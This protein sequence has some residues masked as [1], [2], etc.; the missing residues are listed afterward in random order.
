MFERLKK[1]FSNLFDSDKRQIKSLKT[2][3]VGENE[4]KALEIYTGL[5][6]L[7]QSKDGKYILDS[8]LL[9]SPASSSSQ[10]K[11]G[12]IK[13]LNVN[14]CFNMQ[15][16]EA[17][18]PLHLAVQHCFL[19]LTELF[20]KQ[21]G[22]INSVNLKNQT[23]LHAAC[24]AKVMSA[25]D[26]AKRLD[27]LKLLV[28]ST[29]DNQI[30]DM[31]MKKSTSSNIEED[32]HAFSGSQ[33]ISVNHVDNDGNTAIHYAA[34]NG[35]TEC[36]LYLIDNGA[37]VSIVNNSQKTC[38]E[39]ADMNGDT[40]LAS[41]LELAIVFQEN[42]ASMEEFDREAQQASDALKPVYMLDSESRKVDSMESLLTMMVAEATR[43]IDFQESRERVEVMLKQYNWNIDAMANAYNEDKV[44]ILKK[45]RIA[46]DKYD[47]D[48]PSPA[49]SAAPIVNKT[50]KGSDF[51]E[52][53]KES[54]LS[55]YL[56][57]KMQGE[58]DGNL[59]ESVYDGNEN[60]V[61]KAAV[62]DMVNFVAQ[63]EHKSMQSDALY[64][65]SLMVDKEGEKGNVAIPSIVASEEAYSDN[66][67]L[68]RPH[69][70]PPMPPSTE[71]EKNKLD[72][73]EGGQVDRTPHQEFEVKCCSIC[74]VDMPQ[75]A[76]LN[77]FADLRLRS[78]SNMSAH[79]LS[80]QHSL[81]NVDPSE[82]SITCGSGHSFCLSCWSQYARAQLDTNGIDSLRCPGFKCGEILN[83]QWADYILTDT[84][85]LYEVANPPPVAPSHI[86][87]NTDPSTL[88]D[89]LDVADLEDDKIQSQRLSL[90]EN[91]SMSPFHFDP[92]GQ[93]V[94]REGLLASTPPKGSS[95]MDK[96]KRGGSLDSIDENVNISLS[97]TP[98]L[99]GTFRRSR[100]RR[101]IDTNLSCHHC[102]CSTCDLI[103][104]CPW[105]QLDH[106]VQK[107]VDEKDQLPLQ[108]ICDAGHSVCLLCREEGHAPCTCDD[109]KKWTATIESEM[110]A[111]G[112]SKK[113]GASLDKVAD[114][115]WLHANTKK[116][117]KCSASIEKDEGCNHMTCSNC[118]HDFC[119][120]CMKDWSLHSQASGGYFQCNRFKEE[121]GDGKREGGFQAGSSQGES[122]RLAKSGQKMA[123]FI[124][125]YT[126]FNAHQDSLQKEVQM[127][128]NTFGRI[129]RNL[130]KISTN[131]LRWLHAKTIFDTEHIG[132]ASGEKERLSSGDFTDVRLS[133]PR[134]SNGKDG[135]S[136]SVSRIDQLVDQ[137]NLDDGARVEKALSPPSSTEASSPK[138]SSGRRSFFSWLEDA[139]KDQWDGVKDTTSKWFSPSRDG[140]RSSYGKGK[141]G[142]KAGS[143]RSVSLKDGEES[144]EENEEEEDARYREHSNSL[145]FLRD[146]FDELAKCRQ[147]LRSS[148]AYAFFK[149]EDVSFNR[150]NRLDFSYWRQ[151]KHA[152]KQCF[153]DLQSELEFTVE[154]LSNIVARKRLRASMH[155]IRRM[156]AS[157]RGKRIEFED[158]IQ[159]MAITEANYRME[160]LQLKHERQAAKRASATS[161]NKASH[162]DRS[163]RNTLGRL[164][165][166]SSSGRSAGDEQRQRLLDLQQMQMMLDDDSGMIDINRL[167]E[168]TERVGLTAASMESDNGESD[169][170]DDAEVEANAGE[171]SYDEEERRR[172]ARHVARHGRERSTSF[173]ASPRAS[174]GS[175]SRPSRRLLRRNSP[176]NEREIAAAG[177]NSSGEEIDINTLPG[178]VD[179][180]DHDLHQAILLSLNLGNA[181]AG[182]GNER[183]GSSGTYGNASPVAA[184]VPVNNTTSLSGI[185]QAHAVPLLSEEAAVSMEQELM[186]MMDITEE[187]AR[188]TLQA[189]GYDLASAVESLLEQS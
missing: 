70:F 184:A 10:T 127:K 157:A 50:K 94:Q 83:P 80:S 106:L 42:D 166:G 154:M 3:I 21:G 61:V 119:W 180:D 78:E 168:L 118:A 6:D 125:H 39:L 189:A 38:C 115:L 110:E 170:T 121:L 147:L 33:D 128:V 29:C 18:T 55:E 91:D 90:S 77:Q 43:Q 130:L 63:E 134:N 169:S 28:A 162:D 177:S 129:H 140:K 116:C 96:R 136:A 114:T 26:R 60:L 34:M 58:D 17:D 132:L 92:L 173:S 163:T 102:P 56:A 122:I 86:Q 149:F 111:A 67:A 179:D 120:M 185:T 88:A 87:Q 141:T 158:M 150:N 45:C 66:S 131:E 15:G 176:R 161:R 14:E 53:E 62:E 12:L 31:P 5:D 108:A 113:S 51:M 54:A 167:L 165:S 137:S 37:M 143:S 25:I 84:S 126:R 103:L 79:S 7:K 52:G 19:Q 104:V 75:E 178:D 76:S 82:C 98:G 145:R 156:R 187:K 47:P 175:N 74:M 105:A 4:C 9:S 13:I 159:G 89:P 171:S 135:S 112:V 174:T 153:D 144:K 16:H 57:F 69:I 109:W 160:M 68:S 36:V 71:E 155:E 124:H 59:K 11:K 186:A 164:L 117:P 44:E 99:V 152:M 32:S 48:A 73:K 148:Y 40:S 95:L 64:N 85:D 139:A 27:L 183:V 133:N 72:L 20:L 93:E 22:V 142:K 24:D 2:A 100:V 123:R 81:Q 97:N 46:N 172:A 35:L 151:Q 101:F 23:C 182:G 49:P 30:A 41:E 65:S 181:S 1:G 146:A 107:P 138:K 8:S 188:R